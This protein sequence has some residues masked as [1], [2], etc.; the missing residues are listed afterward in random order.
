[1][2]QT[3]Q[4][5]FFLSKW[6]PFKLI[7]ALLLVLGAGGGVGLT[8]DNLVIKDQE[9]I[10]NQQQ[11]LQTKLAA[12][13]LGDRLHSVIGTAEALSKYSLKDYLRGT[14]SKE[15][16][17]N[18]FKV[19]QSAIDSLQYISLR[20]FPTKQVIS[21]DV[22]APLQILARRQAEEWTDKYFSTLS[23]MQEG[24][25]TPRPVVSGNSRLAGL[26][27]PIWLGNDFKGV[28]TIV[29]DLGFLLDKYITPMQIGKFGSGYVI[30]GSGTVLFDMEKEIVGENIFNLH[31]DFPVL[32][33]LDS[34]M[35]H[36]SSGTGDYTFYTVRE[37][38]EVRKIIAWD[39][40][41]TGD[42]K[43]VIAISAPESDVTDT[44]NS[45][46]TARIAMI[47]FM[48]FTIFGIIFFF[49]YYRSKQIL[50]FQNRELKRKDEL[51]EAI[52]LN[53]PGA[54]YKCEHKPPYAMEYI[55][56]KISKISGYAE[57]E[58]LNGGRSRFNDI[59]HPED[60]N[61]IKLSIEK[62]I[63]EKNS[64]AI[65]YRITHCDG[66]QRWVHERGKKLAE[67]NS[68]VGFIVDITERKKELQALHLAEEKYRLIV[69]SAPLGIFQSSPD[70]RFISA[71]P[72][73][74]KYYGYI[75]E[76]DLIREITDIST[77]CYVSSDTRRRL[78]T[79]MNEFG[80][81]AN[82]EAEH[83]CRDGSTF[84]GAETVTAVKD[85]EG[86]IIRYDGFMVDI[87]ERKEHE[88]TMRRLAMYDSL[89]GLP[90]RV[91]F[92]DRIKQAISHAKRTGMKVA[93][94]YADLDNFK[95][96]NDELGHIA[97]DAVL[98]EVAGRFSDCLRTSDTVSRIGG[99][100][101]IFIL[102]DVGSTN[103]VDVV[104]QR[105][106]DA[107]R[108]PFYLAEK[109]YRLGVS[110]GISIYPESGTEKE[111]L[112]RMADEAMYRAKTSGKNSF[113]Y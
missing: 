66:S 3:K 43:L 51:F 4:E 10:F 92:D 58:F 69:D 5:Q 35:L 59:I 52:S 24:Y 112:V 62:A 56:P 85:K 107:M 49:Y 100:E 13:A 20:L 46:R 70:G 60:R 84:W 75:N 74:A 9:K 36:E 63:S 73:L 83:R 78:S 54:I 2:Q 42:L 106:I 72:Q 95:P 1:M 67:D 53:V 61:K 7:V 11:A 47:A 76:Q 77:Q 105:I 88:E 55:S 68:V 12:T 17:N 71:N 32:V 33:K 37:G 103:E 28:L 18:L 45:V 90:N 38:E 108:A 31:R 57:F 16:I 65:E 30:D 39:T 91:L 15:S 29:I 34:R 40:I 48:G 26:L 93:I 97:G 113:F 22:T 21:S 44:M 23:G 96:V 25:I 87:S 50:I 79:I 86:N 19:K 94:L 82:F 8:L 101:F 110:I 99:D 81:T 98:K 41:K 6:I 27:L 80:H 109:V 89:T 102:Q 104:A 14:R 64:F 111:V